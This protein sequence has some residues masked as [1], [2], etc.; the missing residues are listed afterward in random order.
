MKYFII[1]KLLLTSFYVFSESLT[2]EKLILKNGLIYKKTNLQ[3]PFSG[4]VKGQHQGKIINGKKEGNW[5]YKRGNGQLWMT[6]QY[7]NGKEHGLWNYYDHRSG[8]IYKSEL[9]KKGR[10][11]RY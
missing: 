10:C 8:K 4:I 2:W 1:I 11:K 3:E 6:G 7:L 5:V 9:C